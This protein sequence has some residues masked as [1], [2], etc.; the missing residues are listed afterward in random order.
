[1]VIR[2]RPIAQP[3]PVQP[4]SDDTRRHVGSGFDRRP[5]DQSQNFLLGRIS[6]LSLIEVRRRRFYVRCW[7]NSGR[8]DVRLLVQVR[9]AGVVC[10]EAEA[11]SAS[12]RTGRASPTER[13]GNMMVRPD[14]GGCQ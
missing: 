6:D 2:Q 3:P 10:S 1:M 8:Y 13:L 5:V 7:M 9:P 12:L 14:S 11:N 4:G